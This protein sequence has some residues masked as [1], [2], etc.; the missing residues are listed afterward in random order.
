MRCPECNTFLADETKKCPICNTEIPD[1]YNDEVKEQ[2]DEDNPSVLQETSNKRQ[3]YYITKTD[4][5]TRIHTP[6]ISKA[7]KVLL[8]IINIVLFALAFVYFWLLIET[9][10]MTLTELIG[11]IIAAIFV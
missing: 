8:I 9:H 10:Q 11:C 7:E 1:G 3:G 5:A 6:K 2:C 4:N